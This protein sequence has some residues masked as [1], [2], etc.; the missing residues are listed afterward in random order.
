MGVTP[1]K[2]GNVLVVDRKSVREITNRGETV[3]TFVREDALPHKIGSLQF[4]WGLPN[5]IPQ[6]RSVGFCRN[7]YQSDY[8]RRS[9]S[10]GNLSSRLLLS[11]KDRGHVRKV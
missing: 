7:L 11:P 4:A 3:A 6:H 1:L 10:L 5:V 2:N 8:R 9:R